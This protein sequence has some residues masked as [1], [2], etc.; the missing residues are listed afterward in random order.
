MATC[1]IIPAHNEAATVAGLI[2]KIKQLNLD[3]VLVDDDSTDNTVGVAREAG[4]VILSSGANHGKGVSLI[5]GF[6]YAL[7]YGY[8]AV[9][10]MD[11]D[12]QHLPEDI[13]SFL[14]TANT[15][16]APVFI[17]NRMQDTKRMPLIRLLV[18]KFLS[19]LISSIT[20]QNIPDSQCGFRL[21]KA[22]LL[23]KM[24]LVSQRF[25]I[26]S[27]I[28]IRA[29]QLGSEIVSIP[30]KTVYKSNRSHIDSFKD[31][32]RFIWFIIKEIFKR[33]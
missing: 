18:N 32:F 22:E 5:R 26:E 1:V 28:L 24:H 8:E 4:A 21:I 33:D 15:S 17:G 30:I 6:D 13:P 14:N 2:K 25:E 23:K 16:S 29:S 27:E 12:G 10:T 20:G 9:L 11:G 3:V 7:N 31:T 19:W